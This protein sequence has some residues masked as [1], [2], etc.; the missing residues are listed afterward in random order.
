MTNLYRNTLTKGAKILSVIVFICLSFFIYDYLKEQETRYQPL[1]KEFAGQTDSIAHYMDS[2]LG[3]SVQVERDLKTMFLGDSIL[4][5]F[6]SIKESTA[7]NATKD[8]IST[9]EASL[10][11]SSSERMVR[12]DSIALKERQSLFR[13]SF[14]TEIKDSILMVKMTN[15]LNKHTNLLGVG[16]AFQPLSFDPDVQLFAPYL[17]R[18]P[19]GI[20][21]I[22]L[23]NQINYATKSWYQ[24]PLKNGGVWRDTTYQFIG[25]QRVAEY[26]IPFVQEHPET[27][28]RT[29]MGIIFMHYSLKTIIA[30]LE[31]AT[32]G[33]NAYSVLLSEKNNILFCSADTTKASFSKHAFLNKIKNVRIPKKTAQ[34]VAVA[35]NDWNNLAVA[36]YVSSIPTTGW[37]LAILF[38]KQEALKGDRKL[39]RSTIQLLIGC[40]FFLLTFFFIDLLRFERASLF[41]LGVYS[42]T[43]AILFSVGLGLIWLL[44]AGN[45][46]WKNND[47]I[48]IL[49]DNDLD[50]LKRANIRAALIAKQPIPTYIP[51][52]V[53]VQSIEF[54]SA[55]NVVLTGYIWQKY[56]K[57]VDPDISRGFVLPEAESSEIVESY[58]RQEADG[59]TIGWYFLVT[60]RQKFDYSLYPLDQQAV[61]IRL[62]HE[63]FDKNVILTPA[64]SSYA[65]IYPERLPGIEK[66]FVLPGW[67]LTSSFFN[68]RLNSYNTDFGIP[69][70]VGQQNF[71]E[72]YFQ[73]GMKRRFL[74][75]FISNLT[76]VIVVL[77]MLFAV[78]IT[79]SK[80]SN[81]IEILG[82][83]ASTILASSSAL[84]FV[85]LISHIE[86]RKSLE[87]N[88]VIYM[89]Y[90]YIVTYLV[91]LGVCVNS[92]IFSLDLKVPF[93]QFR[94]NLLPKLFYWPIITLVLFLITL[95]V[96][97]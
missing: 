59:E 73:I 93:V 60:L 63:D 86:L 8:F 49:N 37:S 71:P 38:H 48:I 75:P 72:L 90:F 58:R 66:D 82:F 42:T 89:E 16:I 40:L 47:S 26:T 13:K 34:H 84:F 18:Q 3:E 81:R 22:Q 15:I 5:K 54:S 45:A 57:H 64:L 10:D 17:W 79:C 80:D 67:R 41:R 51:T 44:A 23:E 28:K 31:A 30:P 46:V 20:K 6:I 85:V 78:L 70:Y 12:R 77:Q 76:P 94:D 83:N 92:I 2:I 32:M 36:G 62:W 21:R 11:T 39:Y 4:N 25:D 87:A 35:G 14:Y 27:G 50:S 29:V 7:E 74:S 24:E 56:A 19:T 9:E 68:Y 65:S 61:W 53:F 69:R 52:G 97:Y 1:S 43:I 95:W 33:R 91:L 88:N 96:F 55:N